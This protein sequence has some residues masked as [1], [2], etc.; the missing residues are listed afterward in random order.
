ME[1]MTTFVETDA[2]SS[3]ARA[4]PS[5]GARTPARAGRTRAPDAGRE[6]PATAGLLGPARIA[7]YFYHECERYLRYH[8]TPRAVRAAEGVPDPTDR[9][10]PVTEAI[11]ADGYTWEERVVR[12]HLQSKAHVAPG[13]GAL[14]ERAHGVRETL[15]RL[16]TLRPGEYLY[17]P[18]LEAPEAFL[19]RYGLDPARCRF[20]PCRPDLLHLIEDERGRRLQAI[21]VKASHALKTSH[22]IQVA[23]YAL[24]LRDVLAAAGSSL[25]VDLDAGGVWLYGQ[26]APEPVE[27][28][29]AVRLLERFLRDDLPGILA[30]PLAE[31]PWHLF[32]RCEWCEFFGHCR[33]EAEATGS[34]SLLPYL[35]VGGRRFLREAPW[36]GPPIHTLDDLGAFL[37]RPPA[38]VD[39]DLDACG[40]LRGRRAHLRRAVAALQEGAVV[41]HGGSSPALPVN[42]HV[43]LVLT[44]HSDP[45]S[46]QIYAAGLLRVKGKDVYG[47][48]SRLQT[49]IAPTPEACAE[50][51][52]WLVEALY[53]ELDA[54]HRHNAPLP[55][56]QDKKTLQVYAFDGYE[57]TLLT[58]LL[59]EALADP[60]LAPRALP[61]LFYFQNERLAGEEAHPD[62][63]VPY[64]V[65][66]LTGVIRRL[67]ALPQPL[68]LRLPEALAALPAPGFNYRL[69]P[70]DR[71][72][73]ALSNTL[74]SDALFEVWSGRR[75]EEALDGLRAELKRRL[76]AASAVVDGLRARVG[77]TLFAW[78]PRFAFPETRPFRH[79]E[80]SQLT[81]VTRYESFLQAQAVR[82]ARAAPWEERVRSGTSI[83]LRRLADGRWQIESALDADRIEPGPFPGWVLVR[84]GAAGERAQMGYDDYA[85]RNR[86]FSH[87]Q[88]GWWVAAVTAVDAPADGASPVRLRLNVWGNPTFEPDAAMVLHPRFT[89]YT[90]DR[91]AQC[92]VGLDETP[93]S[94]P[95]ALLRDPVGFARPVPSTEPIQTAL[96]AQARRPGLTESQGRAFRQ[97]RD[98][99]LTL[100]WG[101]PGTGKTHFLAQATLRL[102]AAHAR[103]GQSLRVGIAAFTH[104][105]IENLLLKIGE[106]RPTAGLDRVALYK[107]KE[108][109]TQRGLDFGLEA[110]EETAV[111]GRLAAESGVVGGTVYGFR[112]ARED[113]GLPPVDVLIV[114]EASQMK[115]GELALALP[116]L[117][118][119]GRLVLAGDDLQLPPIVQGSYPA[120]ADGRPGLH[121]SIFAYLRA[122]DDPA[123]PYT[124]PLLENWRANDTLCRFPARALYGD[125]YQPATETVRTRR[126]ALAPAPA[127]ADPDD[128]FVEWLL[129]PAYPLAL[130]VLEGVRAA[131]ENRVEAALVARLA[132]AL[133]ARLHDRAGATYPDTAAGD[134]AFWR[135]GLFVVSPHHAQIDAIRR[136]L[137]ARRAW[138]AAPFVDTVDK[139]QGQESQAV[140]VSYGVS[141]PET[142]AGEGEFLYSLNRLNVAVTR[143]RAKCVVF[144]PRPLLEPSLDVLQNDEA[145]RGLGFMQA[146]VEHARAGGQTAAFPLSL[147]EAPAGGRLVG[148]RRA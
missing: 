32:F 99:R 7:R 85:N 82:E 40:S 89:D 42:E 56:W 4:R 143:A 41:A 8:A 31:A 145:A 21:D 30:R 6:P 111:A 16:A 102:M 44:L 91:I 5:D 113:G 2:S 136:A 83:P 65:V 38:A 95:L 133:R 122:R 15:A 109:R 129:D 19:A 120:R 127:T 34:V 51:R 104:A 80:W 128:A 69:Q 147:P 45:H 138:R 71:Y 146:L 112:K 35:S 58:R 50:A 1:T 105:A 90:S 87:P 116:S 121:D 88:K 93:D 97:V 78:P 24:L 117:A 101:P 94:D 119:N 26:P 139:M 9:P 81:F 134:G 86:A 46:G 66:V 23:L 53:A 43:K 3:E 124:W 10:S 28:G 115:F 18:T 70:S 39:A 72:W 92:L 63:E 107:L 131:Q 76:W 84:A 14:H 52:A 48:G 11:L 96:E 108:V 126:I 64:P 103:A 27:L 22:R 37:D 12:D 59:I 36:G 123:R 137:R 74:K 79:P 142:A 144:L 57:Q 132:A 75:P 47:D 141:D 140:I 100:V 68:A 13:A 49:W 54:L 125:A 118:P 98:H 62:G 17:Q 29:G 25:P 73:F 77:H 67:L 130:G 148:F 20:P 55:R 61:L 106:E 60:A 135:E 33:R 110:V 114:D